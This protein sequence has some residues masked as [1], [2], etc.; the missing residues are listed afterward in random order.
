[1]NPQG[2]STRFQSREGCHMASSGSRLAWRTNM[3]KVNER[4]PRATNS[5]HSWEIT[6]PQPCNAGG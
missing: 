5:S 6:P 1:L 3:D 2:C 4:D